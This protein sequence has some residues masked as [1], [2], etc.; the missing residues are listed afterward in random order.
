VSDL[1]RQPRPCITCPWRR[2]TPPGAF[3]IDRYQQLRNTVESPDGGSPGLADPMFA[4][5]NTIEGREAACAGWLAVY[6]HGHVRVRL[7][8]ATGRI[9]PEALTPAA[10][11]PDLYGDYDELVAAMAGPAGVCAIPVPTGRPSP[12]LP[13]RAVR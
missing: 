9:P 11:W 8:V 3:G 1:P 10:G 4:C 2:D 13:Y 7:A 6:G 12:L 5:H